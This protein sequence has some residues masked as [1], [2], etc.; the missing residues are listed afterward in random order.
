MRTT[1]LRTSVLAL[2][3][4]LA[5]CS[6]AKPTTAPATPAPTTAAA[7]PAPAGGSVVMLAANAL[8][9]IVVDANGRTLYAFTPD[10]AGGIPTCN[11]Q[12]AANWPALLVTGTFT[13][14]AGLDQS[15]FTTVA[16]TDNAGDQLKFAEYP[17]YY[18]SGDSAAGQTNGQGVG[19]KWFVVGADGEQIKP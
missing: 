4:M 19:G 15:K 12:C 7:T 3:L 11:D 16:R 8:G 18:F 17:L 13:V 10:E 5:A 14:G 6:G 9:Q 2:G 1:F